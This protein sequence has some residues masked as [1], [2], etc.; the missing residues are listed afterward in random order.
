MFCIP[1]TSLAI[2]IN[3]AGRRYLFFTTGKFNIPTF[4]AQWLRAEKYE[5][6]ESF[7]RKKVF[8]TS[9]RLRGLKTTSAM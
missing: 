9:L 8:F 7:P 3:S 6:E 5:E 4:H 1:Q 2:A